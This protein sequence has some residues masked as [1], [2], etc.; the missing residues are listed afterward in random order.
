[1]NPRARTV[2]RTI[3]RLRR[4]LHA[5]A[6]HTLLCDREGFASQ[7]PAALREAPRLPAWA[8]ALSALQS[9]PTEA[10]WLRVEIHPRLALRDVRCHLIG[11]A[12]AYQGRVPARYWRMK[13]GRVYAPTPE[14]A[15]EL[16]TDARAGRG[17]AA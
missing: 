14:V 16:R 1:M 6:G 9:S 8:W 7:L 4:R 15:R 5:P 17:G 11:V 2:L 10:E 12:R 3:A 13:S